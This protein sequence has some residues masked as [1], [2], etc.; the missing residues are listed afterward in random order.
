MKLTTEQ[1]MLLAQMAAQGLE[2]WTNIT[3]K[4]GDGSAASGDLEAAAGN[5]NVSIDQFEKN[6]AAGREVRT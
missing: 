3:K 4:I 5:L 2:F 1:V 6:V